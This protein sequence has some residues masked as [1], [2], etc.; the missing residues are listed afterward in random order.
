MRLAEVTEE[1]ILEQKCQICGKQAT[2][3]LYLV[4]KRQLDEVIPVC[5]E[6]GIELQKYG[7][8]VGKYLGMIKAPRSAGG[9]E[10][11]PRG[12]C[13]SGASAARANPRRLNR[14]AL[15]NFRSAVG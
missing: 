1:W 15:V 8:D 13:A 11:F 2:V 12:I 7:Q 14:R 9:G 5:T 3:A 4:M 6:H 10:R